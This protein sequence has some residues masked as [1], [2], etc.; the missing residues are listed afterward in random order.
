MSLYM[1]YRH[2]SIII[3]GFITKM[4][5]L[6]TN[7]LNLSL[8]FLLFA[9]ALSFSVHAETTITGHVIKVA[10]GDTLTLRVKNR[11]LKIRLAEIDT[12]EKAQSYGNTAR[13][14]LVSKVMDKV[15]QV[16]IVTTDRYGRSIGHLYLNNQHI[17]AEMIKEGHAWVYR[18]YLKDTSLL[19]VEKQARI[20]KRGLWSLPISE[21]QAPWEWR[22]NRRKNNKTKSTPKLSN[23]QGCIS[24]KRYCKHMA[25]CHEAMFYL[26][27]CHRTRMDGDKD[28]IPCETT[29]CRSMT[30]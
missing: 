24:S 1:L 4:R 17:N 13:L 14:A 8:H 16:R 21:R 29:H 9:F 5:T 2:N 20:A 28:G 15:I 18:K 30:K 23:A 12:P 22:K 25:N 6:H 26:N 3:E 19:V 10:D 27:Q 7:H 11:T